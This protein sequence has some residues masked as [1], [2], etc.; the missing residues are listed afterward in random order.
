ML[1]IFWRITSFEVYNIYWI[2]KSVSLNF[3]N[4]ISDDKSKLLVFN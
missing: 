3:V 4:F 2:S 1:I